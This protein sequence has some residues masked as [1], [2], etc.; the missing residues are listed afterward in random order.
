MTHIC[1][2]PEY[3]NR[4][5]ANARLALELALAPIQRHPRMQKQRINR[6][7]LLEKRENF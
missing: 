3:E 4:K 2:T 7:E 6:Y 1:R 5:F